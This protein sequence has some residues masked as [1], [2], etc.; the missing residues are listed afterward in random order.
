MCGFVGGGN[1]AGKNNAPM[2]TNQELDG[3][4]VDGSPLVLLFVRASYVLR[5]CTLLRVAVLC[6]C[7]IIATRTLPSTTE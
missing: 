7:F 1:D 4:D 2:H 3:K 6:Q 5:D